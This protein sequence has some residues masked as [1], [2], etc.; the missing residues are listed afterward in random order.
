M[1]TKIVQV[2]SA[3]RKTHPGFDHHG[4]TVHRLH[5]MTV[6]D[7]EIDAEAARLLGS[8]MHVEC[9]PSGKKW[10]VVQRLF[11]FKTR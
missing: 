9:D 4:Q 2:A 7:Q 10:K 11:D 6:T 8:L 3:A 1:T 5:L